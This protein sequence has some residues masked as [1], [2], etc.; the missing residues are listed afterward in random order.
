MRRSGQGLLAALEPQRAG[1]AGEAGSEGKDLG[2]TGC[3]Q[4]GMRQFHVL[5]SARLHRARDVD[6]EQQLARPQPPSQSSEP[7]HL[8]VIADAVAQG[9]PQIGKGTVAGAHPTMATPTRQPRRCLAG[10]AA[11]CVAGSACREAPLDQRFGA[12]RSKA[13]FIRF[14][15][16]WQ[17]VSAAALLLEADNFLVFT[18]RVLDRLAAAEVDVE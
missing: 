17:L 6:Q 12:C 3:L 5:F 18:L 13:G 7:K 15:G 8:A 16:K 9:T 14:I 1:D 10:E 4:Q 2:S 11:Q